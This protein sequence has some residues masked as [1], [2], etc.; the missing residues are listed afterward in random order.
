MKKVLL[1]VGVFGG[2]AYVLLV[3]GWMCESAVTVC[4][5]EWILA[6]LGIYLLCAVAIKISRLSKRD[7][8]DAAKASIE[9]VQTKTKASIEAVQTKTKAELAE[10]KGV[11]A[12]TKAI[13]A[14]ATQDA[15]VLIKCRKCNGQIAKDAERCP[16]CGGST[17]GELVTMVAAGLFVCVVIAAWHYR[18]EIGNAVDQIWAELFGPRITINISF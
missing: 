15:N 2:A 6:I 4:F 11:A 8:R 7:L 14:E 18:N 9:A 1:F 16:H 13:F 10:I 17:A 3:Y 12:E 5:A